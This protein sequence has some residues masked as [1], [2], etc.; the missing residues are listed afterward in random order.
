MGLIFE[1]WVECKEVGTLRQSGVSPLPHH[2]P[3]IAFNTAISSALTGLMCTPSANISALAALIAWYIATC[4]CE[5]EF[6]NSGSAFVPL[7]DMCHQCLLKLVKP[8]AGE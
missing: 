7:S 1:G 3:Q 2:S 4:F 8:K 5:F 6:L